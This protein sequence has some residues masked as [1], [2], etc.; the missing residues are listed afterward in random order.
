MFALTAKSIKS[1]IATLAGA[2]PSITPQEI[3]AAQIAVV[4]ALNGRT[5]SGITNSSPIDRVLTRKQVS[6]LL[7][8]TSVTVSRYA[9]L[10]KIR[11]VY[12][13]AN[14]MRATGY[15]ESSVRALLAGDRTE[16]ANG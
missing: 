2:D 10:G 1:A 15:A 13:G 8:V 4:D 5:I 9:K 16:K 12:G 3:T 14:S 7:G 11:C 6:E